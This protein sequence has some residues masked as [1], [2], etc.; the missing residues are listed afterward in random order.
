M[1]AA[2]DAREPAARPPVLE[3]RDLSKHFGGARALDR[4]SLEI[5]AGEVHGLLGENGS[6][7]STLIKVL[8]GFHVPEAGELYVN[9]RPIAFPLHTG[10]FRELGMSF[11]HQDLGLLPSLTVI[12]NLRIAEL[13][14]RKYRWHIPWRSERRRARS[15]FAR[16]QFHVDPAAPVFTLKPIERAILAIIRAVEE[17]RAGDQ[18]RGAH[19]LLVL[20]EPTVFLPKVD[21]D[22]LFRLVRDIVAGGDSVLFV[23][24][25]L[26]E[27]SD[28][29]DRITVLRDGRN[30][31]TVV[32]SEATQA[33]LVELIIGRR[34]GSLSRDHE[35]STKS[36]VYLRVRG[37]QS[38]AFEMLTFEASKGEVLG[39][40]GLAGSG[41][42]EVPYLLFGAVKPGGGRLELDGN[43]LDL[44]QMTPKRA[45]GLG[46][47]FVPADR[48]RDGA[49]ASLPIVDNMTLQVLEE[50]F[51][52]MFLHRRGMRARTSQLMTT[53]DV[54]PAKPRLMYSSLSGGNQQKA[55]LAKWMQ[56]DPSLLLL[57]EP[58]QGVDVGARHQIFRLMRRVASS[59]ACV[60]CASSD[61]EQLA[62]VCDRVLIFDR[63][64]IVQE[65]SGQDVTKERIAEQSYHS[66][67]A[68]TIGAVSP[69]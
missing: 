56:T 29:T 9:G 41:F 48:Q 15:I 60:I 35:S 51:N 54:R 2:T 49:V 34:L 20:D 65:L 31:G 18:A 10:Q 52:N 27:V 58:T 36:N 38:C 28:I 39:L 37:L 61:Y 67:A 12:E 59:G 42:E 4:A 45:V 40:T 24:H 11:V 19:G 43:D 69:S 68:P 8:A 6:G 5:K 14:S 13:S 7:K 44:V 47:A 25:D 62:A 16:Y 3:V 17:L 64:S 30:V 57:H 53:Y 55:L 22:R 1:S 33:V 23:S 63:G 50:F 46:L 26:D 21:V 66:V 32:T